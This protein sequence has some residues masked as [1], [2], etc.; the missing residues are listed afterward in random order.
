MS[1][2]EICQQG[3]TE[4]FE[5]ADERCPRV[6]ADGGR[7]GWA[8]EAACNCAHLHPDARCIHC[9][10]RETTGGGN[11]WEPDHE[12]ATDGGLGEP[13]VIVI[14]RETAATSLFEV[15]RAIERT[16]GADSSA[17][18]SCSPLAAVLQEV[19]DAD[20]KDEFDRGVVRAII[21]EVGEERNVDT[22]GADPLVDGT[23]QAAQNLRDVL[24]PD[25]EDDDGM[26]TVLP[27]G[28][29]DIDLETV[30]VNL[31]QREGDDDDDD[32]APPVA[33]ADGGRKVV[34]AND[35]PTSPRYC[36]G[37]C[38]RRYYGRGAAED[39]CNGRAGSNF[40]EGDCR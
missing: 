39:C 20:F 30:Q 8:P 15:E 19:E 21:R 34:G 10:N 25:D 3:N 1:A 5:H 14:S 12:I 18:E 36:C 11:Y 13:E 38:S 32:S 7:D 29:R 22:S 27:D 4:P 23:F 2:C 35:E 6:M 28:G 31:A 40:L 37:G 16:G 33:I 26:K 9:H 17:Q 24:D